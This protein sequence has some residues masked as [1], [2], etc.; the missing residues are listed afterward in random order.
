MTP[1][2]IS[3]VAREVGLAPS[4]IRY[5][6]QIGILAPPQRASGQRRYDTAA[7]YR[8]AVLQRAR[9]IGFT[10]AEIRQ[11]FFGFRN[12]APASE[13]WKK[14]SR[15]KLAEL[16]EQMERIKTMQNVLQRLQNCTCSALEHCGKQMLEKVRGGKGKSK[17]IERTKTKTPR[18]PGMRGEHGAP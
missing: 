16:D 18:A 13:R 10:L 2:T 4:T 14:L 8:L 15:L 17:L 7:I 9:Q 6:E 3:E 1:L 12:A 11:L 5:Y